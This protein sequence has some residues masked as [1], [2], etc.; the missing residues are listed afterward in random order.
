MSITRIVR[1]VADGEQFKF[2]GKGKLIIVGNIGKGATVDCRAC[3]LEIQGN[4]GANVKIHSVGKPTITGEKGFNV[5]YYI[6]NESGNLLRTSMIG[7]EGTLVVGKS[8]RFTAT[9][10]VSGGRSESKGDVYVFASASLPKSEE[11]KNVDEE[12]DSDKESDSENESDDKN[13]FS[14]PA[15]SFRNV[16]IT[17]V[18]GRVTLPP[19]AE[20]HV[21]TP[22]TGHTVY[23]NRKE[24]KSSATSQT[25]SEADAHS[26]KPASYRG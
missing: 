21:R 6:Y 20:L 9:A 7:I 2:E 23:A 15:M 22:Y 8:G 13:S 25:K 1:D 19:G 16:K 17:A 10:S 12:P 14:I 11:S 24:D 18:G 26:S 3:N 4:R 5:T